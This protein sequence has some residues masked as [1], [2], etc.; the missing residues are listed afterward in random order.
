MNKIEWP[1]AER[2]ILRPRGHYERTLTEYPVAFLGTGRADRFLLDA[3]L[4]GGRPGAVSVELTIP[5]MWHLRKEL[6]R[7][8]G[9]YTPEGQY[10]PEA[11]K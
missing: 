6:N 3:L 8:L 9:S 4:P 7:I 10:G 2:L 1:T 11:V 5:E